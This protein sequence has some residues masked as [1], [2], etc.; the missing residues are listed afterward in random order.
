MKSGTILFSCTH[1]DAQY[2]KW[3][4]RCLTCGQWSTIVESLPSNSNPL[5]PTG[6]TVLFT[7]I[8][9]TNQEAPVRKATGIEEIDRVLGGGIVPGSFTLLGGEPGIGKSTLALHIAAAIPGSLYFSGEESVEQIRLRANRMGGIGVSI[10]IAHTNNTDDI[11]ATI[12]ERRPPLALVDS[13][14]TIASGD[15][16]GD[17]GSVSQVRASAGK[18]LQTAKLTGTAIVL[19]GHVTKDGAIAGPKTLEHIVDTVLSFDGDPHHGFRTLR[20]TKNRF[21]GTDDVGVFDM[22][23]RGLVGIPDPSKTLLE[24]TSPAM[25]GSVLTCLVDGRRPFLVEIQALVTKTMFGYPVRKTSGF[26][27][28]RLHLLTAVLQKRTALNFSQHD[29]HLNITGG[30]H[31]KEPAADVAVCLAL[32]SAYKDTVIG[33]DLMAFGEV[34]LGGELKGV[35][36]TE[37][38]VGLA[39]DLGFTRVIVPKHTR[40]LT[41]PQ[42]IRMIDVPTI[43][44]LIAHLP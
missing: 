27:L 3:T 17:M 40:G 5:S 39:R 38:R 32:M 23:E 7:R 35:P 20:A 12:L 41:V 29:I 28:N 33:K 30:T 16:M 10:D 42:G 31:A 18:L 13:I 25:P 4:G 2:P 1:C 43:N 34:G 21:G 37:K 11:V 26:D 14:Q 36:H 19:I 15:A 44:E 6:K 9:E 8:G 24:N 22:T